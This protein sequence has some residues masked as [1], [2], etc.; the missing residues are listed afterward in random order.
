MTP[1][2]YRRSHTYTGHACLKSPSGRLSIQGQTVLAQAAN[3]A[4]LKSP[5]GRLSIQGQTI[6]VQVAN[7][8]FSYH[9]LRESEGE[10]GEILQE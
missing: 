4:C 9:L 10:T 3:H 8:R 7:H 5:L 6:L 1:H 2:L